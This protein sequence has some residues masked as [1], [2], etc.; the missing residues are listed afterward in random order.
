MGQAGETVHVRHPLPSQS[1]THT[2]TLTERTTDL[3]TD[4]LAATS[5]LF[6]FN[7][8]SQP[9]YVTVTRGKCLDD[10]ILIWDYP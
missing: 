7:G 9:E 5:H 3:L 2:H 4:W 6:P 8:I 10:C 1:L